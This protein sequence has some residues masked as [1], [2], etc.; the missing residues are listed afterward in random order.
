MTLRAALL[1]VTLLACALVSSC[2]Q[3]QLERYEFSAPKMGTEFRL[4]LYAASAEQ[5]ERAASR[6]FERVEELEDCM[7]DYR[8][9]SELMQLS[10]HAGRGDWVPLSED[11]ARVLAAAQA[12]SEASGGAFDVSVGP[13]VRLW[14]R[15]RRQERAPGAEA[16][17]NAMQAVGSEKLE[18]SDE[19]RALRLL[20]P[21]MRLDLG[22]IAK[23][24]A[25]D[26]ALVALEQEGVHSA[27]V[28]GGG[29]VRV[30][31]APPGR[32]AWLVRLETPGEPLSLELVDAAVATSGDAYRFVEL[33]GVRYSHIIDPRTGRAL[34]QQATVSVIAL[35]GMTAD[36][37][38]SA[39][40]V[41]GPSEGLEW[42]RAEPRAEA[43]WVWLE[44]DAL[45]S[46]ETPG[47][48]RKMGTARAPSEVPTRSPESP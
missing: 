41:L 3:T 9:Q 29:D 23:G 24:Y 1:P 37:L 2:A 46:C 14:R 5:A 30:G 36:A 34:A 6:A 28:D 25:L 48:E 39:A 42:L 11:L 13:L 16:L 31:A 47:F 43:R 12:V 22:G 8:P 33:E 15:A 7:S 19:G 10:A 45:R 17:E 40:S 32:A 4:V 38:A 21:G 27:L 35:D 26:Q 18:L 20:V 44:N